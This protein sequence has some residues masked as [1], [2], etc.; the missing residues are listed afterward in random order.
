MGD[1]T[2]SIVNRA[3]VPVLVARAAKSSEVAR[4]SF[5]SALKQL[6]VPGRIRARGDAAVH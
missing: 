2:R 5:L 6:F 1:L 4:L 3:N